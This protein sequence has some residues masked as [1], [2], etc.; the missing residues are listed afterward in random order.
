ME[1]ASAGE[2][3]VISR[4]GAPFARLSP[5]HDQLDLAEAA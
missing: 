5:P 2:T 3:F 4:F 1:R